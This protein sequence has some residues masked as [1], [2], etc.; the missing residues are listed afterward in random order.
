M[1]TIDPCVPS[2]FLGGEWS[3]IHASAKMHLRF[4]LFMYA[5]TE[6]GAHRITTRKGGS[7]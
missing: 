5:T 1:K 2:I 6:P 7:T 4:Y 3:F